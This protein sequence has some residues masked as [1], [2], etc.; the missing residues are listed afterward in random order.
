MLYY[1]LTLLFFF[2]DVLP[3]KENYVSTILRDCISPFLA[4]AAPNCI[5]F[6]EDIETIENMNFQAIDIISQFHFSLKQ[7]LFGSRRFSDDGI[8]DLIKRYQSICISQSCTFQEFNRKFYPLHDNSVDELLIMIERLTQEYHTW[9]LVEFLHS[10]LIKNCNSPRKMEIDGTIFASERKLIDYL[11]QDDV[12]VRRYNAVILWLEEIASCPLGNN[13]LRTRCLSKNIC[14]ENTLLELKDSRRKPFDSKLVSEIDPDSSLRQN[15]NLSELDQNDEL[16][17]SQC[18]WYHIRAGRIQEAQDLL[19]KV[20]Q[21][22]KAGVFEGEKYYHDPN[23]GNK[24]EDVNIPEIIEGNI[25]RDIWK[26]IVW[27]MSEDNRFNVFERAIY[28]ALAGNLQSMLPVCKNWGDWLWAS[29]KVMLDVYYESEIRNTSYYG[30]HNNLKDLPSNY[31]QQNLEPEVIFSELQ[32]IQNEG[33]RSFANSKFGIIQFY[34]ITNQ[35]EI[36][37]ETVYNWITSS[38]QPDTSLGTHFLRFVAHLVIYCRHI[39]LS[40]NDE[41]CDIIIENYISQLIFLKQYEMVSTYT[42]CITSTFRQVICYSNLLN[43]I[44]KIECQKMCLDLAKES[45]LNINLIIQHIIEAVDREESLSLY[46]NDIIDDSICLSASDSKKIQILDWLLY[47]ENHLQEALIQ[48]LTLIRLFLFMKKHIAASKTFAKLPSNILVSLLDGWKRSHGSTARPT[49]LDNYIK[50]Y[51]CYSAYFAAKDAFEDWITCF[52][53]RKSQTPVSKLDVSSELLPVEKI[54]EFNTNL[55]T[56]QEPLESLQLTAKNTIEKVLLFEGGWMVDRFPLQEER[57]SER[58]QQQVILRTIY[59]PNM[60]F[61]LYSLLKDCGYYQSCLRISNLIA[62]EDYKL[63]QL[64]NTQDSKR[65]LS[66]MK[67][68]SVLLSERKEIDYLGYPF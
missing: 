35:L 41:K 22:L 8:F 66:L 38:R 50:E 61:L 42:A 54:Q 36:L 29:Y 48:G 4:Q 28:G 51:L 39:E 27:K 49:Y 46:Q 43:T 62:S 31:W 60:C 63:Y 16:M 26:F 53:Q 32:G 7:L 68:A 47:D 21:P 64:F 30:K 13:P 14:F 25:K 57:N 17:L 67:E 55:S 34:L 3:N 9:K 59:I 40:V 56:W 15:K 24:S 52:Y 20:G 45:G 2:L 12:N 37:I 58:H 5:P 19:E 1:L 10:E 33:I 11:L 65:F 6:K 44:P 23:F 18:V